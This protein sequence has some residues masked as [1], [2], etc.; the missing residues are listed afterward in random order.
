MFVQLDPVEIDTALQENGLSILVK[1]FPSVR[2]LWPQAGAHVALEV[3]ENVL[4]IYV[5][6]G[7][8]EDPT[9]FQVARS[10]QGWMGASR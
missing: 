10:R 7:T 1:G 3:R 5:W 8:S 9:E 2:G 4:H 6:D